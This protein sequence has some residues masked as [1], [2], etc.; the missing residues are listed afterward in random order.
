MIKLNEQIIDVIRTYGYMT[1]IDYK[2]VAEQ[3]DVS[4]ELIKQLSK[5]IK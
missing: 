2:E 3:F 5:E 4:V 1:E